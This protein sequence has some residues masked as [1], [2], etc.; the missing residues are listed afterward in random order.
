MF[1]CL[2]TKHLSHK[3]RVLISD[4]I[5]TEEVIQRVCPHAQMGT[6]SCVVMKFIY[7]IL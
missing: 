6:K 7:L 2:D 1:T 4:C 5:M 3:S